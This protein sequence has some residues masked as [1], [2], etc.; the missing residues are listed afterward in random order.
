MQN[1]LRQGGIQTPKT[2]YIDI[3]T[4]VPEIKKK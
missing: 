4:K 3:L 1:L 2:K